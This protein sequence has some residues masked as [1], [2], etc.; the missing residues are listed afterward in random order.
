MPDRVYTAIPI[1]FHVNHESRQEAARVY[2]K[3]GNINCFEYLPPHVFAKFSIDAIYVYDDHVLHYIL[4]HDL[5]TLD[6]MRSLAITQWLR[7]LCLASIGKKELGKVAIRE[8][9]I[10]KRA[11]MKA[12]RWWELRGLQ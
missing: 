12:G 7:E 5:Q 11:Y 3:E 9:E 8:S 2:K 6:S 1:L 4:Y 10:H